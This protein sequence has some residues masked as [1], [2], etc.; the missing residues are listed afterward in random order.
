MARKV[1]KSKKVVLSHGTTK[2]EFDV[3]HAERLLRLPQNGGWTLIEAD[4]EHYQFDEENGITPK[5]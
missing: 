4:N 5:K 3:D 2:Q 1:E